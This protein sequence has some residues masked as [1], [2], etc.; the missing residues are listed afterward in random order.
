MVEGSN[1]NRMKVRWQTIDEQI[2]ESIRY[3]NAL[4]ASLILVQY[5]W[6]LRQPICRSDFAGGAESDELLAKVIGWM[7]VHRFLV[8]MRV[9]ELLVGLSF[10]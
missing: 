7:V 8:A 9:E 4:C 10:V 2:A 1:E 3:C 5:N 6:P